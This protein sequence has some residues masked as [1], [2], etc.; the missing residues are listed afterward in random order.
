MSA[1][2]GGGGGRSKYSE[3]REELSMVNVNTINALINGCIPAVS[4]RHMLWLY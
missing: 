1:G 3:D 2:G 4:V